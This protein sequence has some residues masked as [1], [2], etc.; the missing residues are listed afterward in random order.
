MID[1]Y[2]TFLIFGYH[3]DELSRWST[4][5]IIV[6]CDV[7]GEYRSIRKDSYRDLCRSCSIK[8]RFKDPVEREKVSKTLSGRQLSQKHRNAISD[9]LKNSDNI[10][11]R[12]GAPRTQDCCNRISESM[13]KSNSHKVASENQRGGHD[14]I[15]HHMIYDHSDLAKNTLPM[16][17]STHTKLHRLFQKYGIEIPHINIQ[18]V[19]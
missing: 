2:Y 18:K 11:A 19:I 17:R 5:P 3:S 8:N 16:T 7:C 9:G 15:K 4:K 10:K 6:I 13:K 14:I 1:E 12:I